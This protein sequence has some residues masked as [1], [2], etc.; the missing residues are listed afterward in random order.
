MIV[1]PGGTAQPGFGPYGFG[2]QSTDT[3]R[4]FPTRLGAGCSPTVRTI[5]SRWSGVTYAI[6][7]PSGEKAGAVPRTRRRTRWSR[8][9]MITT[10]PRSTPAIPVPP[11]DHDGSVPIPTFVRRPGR[12]AQIAPWR[13][14][15]SRPSADHTASLAAPGGGEGSRIPSIRRASRAR[16]G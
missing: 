6:Q 13:T 8:T 9:R 4:M 2:C 7:R 1:D 5:I 11:G 14:T 10:Q 12:P 16:S 15:T 3:A